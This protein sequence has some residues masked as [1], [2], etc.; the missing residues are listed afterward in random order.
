M[1]ASWQD[2]RLTAGRHAIRVKSNLQ[3]AHDDPVA[4][5]IGDMILDALGANPRFLAAALPLKV[6]PPRFNRYEGGGSYGEHV[7]GAIMTA[8]GTSHRMRTDL[9][10][11]LFFSDPGEY[12]GG[13]LVIHDT[14]GEHRV[15]LPAGHLVLYPGTSL[16]QVT[17][18]TRGV[19]HAAFF[20]IQSMVREDAQRALLLTLDEAIQE[21]GPVAPD[22]PALARLLGVYHNLLRGWAA[23]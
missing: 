21:L 9:S 2:G 19:R 16:H 20:W 6:M 7:D 11:T 12:D 4:G 13:E 17:P 22:H 14:Y 1:Q 8:P 15:K 18:V 10:A 3:L 5:R 23:T